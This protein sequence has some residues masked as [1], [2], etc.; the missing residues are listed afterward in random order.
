MSAKVVLIG[1]DSADTA[2]IDTYVAEG[3][4]PTFAGLAQTGSSVD[5]ETCLETLPGAVWPEIATGVSCGK[6]GEIFHGRQL[7]S[8][9]SKLKPLSEN[10]VNTDKYLWKIASDAGKRVAVLDIPETA[11]VPDLNGVSL[12]GWGL[13]DELYGPQTVPPSLLDD[14][15]ATYGEHPMGGRSCDTMAY[16]EGPDA[17]A[18]RLNEGVSA[19][20][21]L[22][23]GVLADDDWDLFLCG[24]GEPHCAGHQ[25]WSSSPSEA[26]RN[27]YCALDKAVGEVIDS[28]GDSTEV[29]IVASHGVGDYI[30]G[31]RLLPE[32]LIRLGMSGRADPPARK[33]I[34][35]L[36]NAGR[37]LPLP[38][39]RRLRRATGKGWGQKVQQLASA[40]VDPFGSPHTLAAPVPNNRCGAIRLNIKGRDPFGQVEPGAERDQLIDQLSEEL[41]ALK[42]PGTDAP[43]IERI[44]T[45]DELFGPDHHPNTPDLILV[46][47]TDLGPLE[48]CTSSSVGLV[49]VP[50]NSPGYP[51]TGDHRPAS[52]LWRTKS[53]AW[54]EGGPAPSSLDIAPTLLKLL[55]VEAPAFID[56]RSLI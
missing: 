46:F 51:R 3:C 17:V 9:E 2:L 23:T 35:Q 22:A 54:R 41:Y 50:I 28:V 11:P 52:R 27:F 20:A 42:Q 49:E 19:K 39:K 44:S 56:G 1:L 7:V 38:I 40:A 10:H 48:A 32:V 16:R 47:R 33:G 34:R 13:H 43:I 14:L 31:P 4:M 37:Y 55:D 21:T 18:K 26:H 5:L 6:L 53:T 15:R 36:Y 30:G 45:A 8:G 29:L 24:F 25:L 12:H